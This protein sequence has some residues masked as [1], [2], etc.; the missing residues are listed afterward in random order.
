MKKISRIIA[1][2]A[3]L[4]FLQSCNKEKINE[5]VDQNEVEPIDQHEDFENQ[6]YPDISVDEGVLS[7]ESIEYYES[8]VSDESK[9]HGVDELIEYLHSTSFDS[10]GK[11]FG[12]ESSYDEPFMDAIMNK[13]QVVKIGEWF[14]F[15]DLPSQVVLAISEK[16]ENAYADLL[17]KANRNLLEFSVEDDVLDHLANNTS[18]QDRACGGIG[19]DTYPSNNVVVGG[20]THQAY[21]KFFSGGIYFKLDCGFETDSPFPSSTT[22]TMEVQS[23][24]GWCKRKPCSSGTIKTLAAGG[25]GG[26]L[27][28]NT[29]YH[30]KF[31]ENVR[32]LNGYYFYVRLKVN[33]TYS[34][35]CGR[36][37]NSPY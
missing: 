37:I 9:T 15:I 5:S 8:I 3:I 10:Y 23:P 2:S 25:L 4:V 12:E 16:E 33:S 22:K 6:K 1:F 17:N 21:V 28:N 11:A 20:V 24:E 13:D 35:W 34:T 31:Y 36:N 14:I 26:N 27:N 18:P 32:N 30:Y 29:Y 7:F 19:G